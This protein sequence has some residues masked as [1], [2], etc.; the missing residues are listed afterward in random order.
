M[1]TFLAGVRLIN[2]CGYK[3]TNFPFINGETGEIKKFCV[4]YGPNGEGKSTL[5]DAI[6]LVGNPFIYKDRDT[7]LMFR[8]LTYHKDYDPTY[9]HMME[10]DIPNRMR[11]DGVFSQV[12]DKGSEYKT[13]VINNAGLKHADLKEKPRGYIY[14]LDADNPMNMS[15]FQ[16]S[17]E[18][19]DTFLDIAK[20][21]YGFECE[22]VTGVEESLKDIDGKN[23]DIKIYTDFVIHKKGVK[24]HF[25][26]MSDGEKKIATLLA[27]LCD[28]LYM[29]NIDI[30]LI[31]NVEMHVYFKRHAAMVDKFIE[32]F[33]DKQFIVTTHSE[34]L[35]EHVRE[36]MGEEFLFD[37]E[38][39]KKG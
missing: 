22:F 37:L 26:R 36:N 14:T 29:D 4:I 7:E 2:Y 10:K 23:Y 8:K 30:I 38:T 17:S 25:K 16:V 20:T 5:L 9:N 13:I 11:L 3:N 39:I 24:V 35:I 28:P 1:N 12:D 34:T 27:Y 32:H 33:P 18:N 15:R 31:D 6:R 19:A 21:V